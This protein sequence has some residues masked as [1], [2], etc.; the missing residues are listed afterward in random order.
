MSQRDSLPP[1]TA[2]WALLGVTLLF[3]SAVYRLGRRGVATLAEGLDAFHLVALLVLVAFFVY[4]EGIRAIQRRYAPYL[5]GRVRQVALEGAGWHRLLAPLYSMSLVGAAPANL[6][7][8]WGGVTAVVAAILVLRVT[9]DPWRGIVDTAVSL[10]LAWGLG[11]ILI[12]ALRSGL[13]AHPS[14]RDAPDPVGPEASFAEE[15]DG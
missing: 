11:S 8:A 10:A 12:Q 14:M 5:L 1:L 7:R 4:G 13:P 6:A 15:R 2:A 9:P 3:G